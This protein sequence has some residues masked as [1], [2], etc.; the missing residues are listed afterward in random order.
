MGIRGLGGFIKWKIPGARKAIQWA[1]HAGE[2]WGIDCS[3]LLYRANGA[4]LSALTVVA[5]L[6]VRMRRAGI[7][8][9]FIFDGKTTDAKSEV[10][11]QRRAVRAETHKQIAELRTELATGDL[12]VLQTA[13]A[14]KRCADLQKKAPIVTSGEKDT[15]KKFLYAA[16]ILFV[17]ASGEADDVLAYLCR[18][19]FAQGVVSTDM[20]MLARGV[21]LLILPETNDASVLTEIA[22]GEVLSGLGLNYKQFV[23]ACMLMGSDYSGKK[24]RSVEPRHAVEMARRGIEWSA[25]DSSGSLLTGIDILTGAHATWEMIMSP[26][27]REKWI[28]GPPAKEPENMAAIAKTAGWPADW[29]LV[30]APPT[31]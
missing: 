11:E 16:G 28:S 19:G 5:S 26:K 22:L 9:V 25:M 3:C 7:T 14:E 6:I 24:W 21:P 8:P 15:L 10:V 18:Q 4:G 13:D 1:R 30:L 29:T 31:A 12:T 17:T 23:E 2:T 20:D 27:Q